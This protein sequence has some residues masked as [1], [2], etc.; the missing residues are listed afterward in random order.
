VV[1]LVVTTAEPADLPRLLVVIVMGVG[2]GLAANLA[3]LSM[4]Q[5]PPDGRSD[6]LVSQQF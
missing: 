6:I 4:K 2:L 1:L 5:S 3:G